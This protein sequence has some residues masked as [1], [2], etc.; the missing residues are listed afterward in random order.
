MN[1]QQLMI[2]AQETA[3]AISAAAEQFCRAVMLYSQSAPENNSVTIPEELSHEGVVRTAGR[4][5]EIAQEAKDNPVQ[6]RAQF[7]AQVELAP[8]A[9][10]IHVP[11][12][13]DSGPTLESYMKSWTDQDR[14][15]GESHRELLRQTLPQSVQGELA[16]TVYPQGPQTYEE[17]ESAAPKTVATPP[18]QKPPTMVRQKE[19]VWKHFMSGKVVDG[20]MGQLE[21]GYNGMKLFNADIDLVP[22]AQIASQNW[23]T[24]FY[25]AKRDSSDVYFL[26]NGGNFFLRL[27]ISGRRPV[28]QL[29]MVKDRPTDG[30]L[31]LNDTLMF[32]FSS[33]SDIAGI[34]REILAFAKPK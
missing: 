29:I 11:E 26:F 7:L 9:T 2:L 22:T 30:W 15:E 6:T 5:R 33:N 21:P 32:E 27:R 31:P 13:K 16:P 8:P 25:S 1:H 12:M 4:L 20:G 3:A 14:E 18:A 28:Q 34:Y 24:G 10:P 19:N 17:V 23:E